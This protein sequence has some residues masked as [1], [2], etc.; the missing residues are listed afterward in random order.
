M[1]V[2]VECGRL[3]RNASE[4]DSRWRRMPSAVQPCGGQLK[5]VSTA[6][7]QT[8]TTLAS[9]AALTIGGLAEAAFL[10]VDQERAEATVRV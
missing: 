8:T 9:P 10:A 1:R 6:L 2:V 4:P 5:R 3:I 7:G